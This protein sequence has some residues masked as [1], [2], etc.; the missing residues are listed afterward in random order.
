MFSSHTDN[1]IRARHFTNASRGDAQIERLV[2]HTTEGRPE[3]S[4]FAEDVANFFKN[5]PADAPPDDRVSS[6]YVV[7]NNSVVGCVEEED[8]A[9]HAFGDNPE[10]IGIELAGKA[11]QTREQWADPY[12]TAQL[13]LAAKLVAD[14]CKRRGIPVRR[15]TNAQLQARERGIVSHKQVSDLF[16]QGIRTD[17]GPN[18]PWGKFLDAVKANLTPKIQYVLQ[19]GEGKEL[20]H[21]APVVADNTQARRER[22]KAFLGNRLAMLDSELEGDNDAVLRRR[23]V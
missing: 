1:V 3:R 17:P 23:K 22:L 11:G 12:S 6:H 20:A 9:N 10:S 7:D 2:M 18:F 4:D 5:I 16:G 21:S 13:A 8:I 14:I 19:D 15:L